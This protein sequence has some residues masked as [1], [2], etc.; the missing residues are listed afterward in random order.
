MVVLLDRHPELVV[1]GDRLAKC[2]GSIVS[3]YTLYIRTYSWTVAKRQ[4]V[5]KKIVQ[6]S[7]I[8]VPKQKIKLMVVQ[9]VGH[10][11]PTISPPK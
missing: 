6:K 3:I 7:P 1:K 2:H 10:E 8:G 9:G 11:P 4:I 5:T